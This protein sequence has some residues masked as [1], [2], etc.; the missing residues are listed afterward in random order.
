MTEHKLIR[1]WN[2]GQN[3]RYT[4]AF[5]C[6]CGEVDRDYVME[7]YARDGHTEHAEDAHVY[8][9]ERQRAVDAKTREA[10]AAG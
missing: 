9:A 7:H 5:R 10:G 2:E 3:R 4:Y 1:V 8:E 6:S